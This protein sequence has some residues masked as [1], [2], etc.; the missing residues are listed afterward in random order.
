MITYKRLL[1]EMKKEVGPIAKIFLDKAMDVL[2]ID[3]VNDTNYKE[4]LEVLKGNREL[5][6]YI[7]IIEKRLEEG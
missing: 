7:Q 4:I 1:D 3:D 2:E 6:E 5:R